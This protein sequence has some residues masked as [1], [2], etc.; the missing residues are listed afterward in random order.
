MFLFIAVLF[1]MRVTSL[2]KQCILVQDTKLFKDKTTTDP[3]L[4]MPKTSFYQTKEDIKAGT[5]VSDLGYGDYPENSEGWGAYDA[6]IPGL[7]T[8]RRNRKKG[9][10]IYNRYRIKI[11]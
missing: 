10:N 5:I 11:L 7:D 6:E 2:G 1:G 4:G 9:N 8:T 3:Y